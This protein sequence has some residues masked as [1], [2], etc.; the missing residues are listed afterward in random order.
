MYHCTKAARSKPAAAPI[1]RGA[2][3]R[4]RMRS[5][6]AADPAPRPSSR[7]SACRAAAGRASVRRSRPASCGCA[8]RCLSRSIT[9]TCGCSTTTTAGRSSTAAYGNEATR[10]LWERHFADDARRQ[11]DRAHHRHPLPPRSCR[12]RRVAVAQRFACPR[13]MTHARVPDGARARRTSTPATVPPTPCALFRQHGMAAGARRGVCR[14]RQRL[15][16]RCAR[17]AGL[18]SSGCVA[19]D[20]R[21]AAGAR[22][23]RSSPAMATRRSTR[24]CTSA[25]RSVL[26][27]GDMLLPRISTNVSVW[28]AEPEGDPLGAVPGVARR[29]RGAAARHAGP[30]LA[31]T[32]VPR[33]RAA[34]RAA[35]RAP[36]GTA[37]RAREA[38]AARRRAGRRRRR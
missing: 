9:S 20:R 37:R 36:R 7:L 3:R 17:A 10:A 1:T 30:A 11:A 21:I 29:L 32:A 26:I 19:G 2:V 22:R 34:G 25:A 28:P 31:W 27:S 23:G 12:Q 13:A 38:I 6:P 33:H 4:R 16:A 8:C 5:R 24:R 14:A 18:S 15:S 35:A